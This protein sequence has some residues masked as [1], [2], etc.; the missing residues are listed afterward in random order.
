MPPKKSGKG[1]KG[2]K[3]KKGKGEKGGK[4]APKKNEPVI[5]KEFYSVQIKDLEVR[6]KKWVVLV[7]VCDI[8]C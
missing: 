5:N 1:G 8:S 4:I 3:G 7:V 6:L 2:G